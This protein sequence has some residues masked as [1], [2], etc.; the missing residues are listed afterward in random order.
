MSR[1]KSGMIRSIHHIAPQHLREIVEAV[2]AD[3]WDEPDLQPAIKHAG[4]SS[5]RYLRE[6]LGLRPG[7]RGALVGM[8]L[9]DP[10][11]TGELI[12]RA[13]LVPR[14]KPAAWLW[15]RFPAGTTE[16]QIAATVP[17]RKRMLP[18]E[19]GLPSVAE[20]DKQLET[21]RACVA[22]IERQRELVAEVDRAT[23]ELAAARERAIKAA[24]AAFNL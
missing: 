5:F 14:G 9:V 11:P 13:Y 3:S 1:T 15:R 19:T 2:P 7:S 12:A 21:A 22:T 23:A 20:L 4:I 17:G 16:E 18:I 24:R 6:L 10:C 8:F